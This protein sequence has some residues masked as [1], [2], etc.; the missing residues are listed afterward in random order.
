MHFY[1]NSCIFLSDSCAIMIYIYIW[2]QHRL[3]RPFTHAHVSWDSRKSTLKVPP[4]LCVCVF[5]FQ[6]RPFYSSI[7]RYRYISLIYRILLRVRSHHACF[8]ILISIALSPTLAIVPFNFLTR[9]HVGWTLSS[10]LRLFDNVSKLV[11]PLP[12]FSIMSGSLFC[13]DKMVKSTTNDFCK[14]RSMRW[15]CRSE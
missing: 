9:W 13:I 14:S 6:S 4:M 8:I 1:L 7:Y 2:G 5:S 3:P 11:P 15:K 10:A 12:H